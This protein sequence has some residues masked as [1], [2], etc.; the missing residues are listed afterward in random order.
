MDELRRKWIVALAIVLLATGSAFAQTTGRI[1][2]RIVDESGGALPGA[3]ITVTSPSLQGASTAVTDSE[4]NYR[5]PTLPSGT[6]TVKVM[7]SGFKTVEQKAVQVGID[8]TVEVN[9]TMPVA[10]VQETVQVEAASPVV[11]TSSTS[12]GIN[13]KADIFNRL[14]I[15]RNIYSIARIAPGTTEDTVGTAV[16]GST[17]A[18]NQYIIEGLN[19][20]GMERGQRQKQLNF[21][22]VQEIEVKT[23]GLPAEYGR[24][25][26][27][28]LNVVTKSGGNTYEGSFFGFSAGGALQ[29]NDKTEA[30]RPTTT[31]TVTNIDRQ[32]DGG[33]NLG[34]YILR[35]RLWFFGAYNRTFQRNNSVVV[36]PLAVAGSP[37]IGT[38]VPAE[39]NSNLFAGK[40]TYKVSNSQ[41]LVLS[42]NGDPSKREGNVF[43]VAG[44]PSTWLGKQT[45]G[46][47]DGVVTYNAVFGSDFLV[48]GMYGRHNESSKFSGLGKDT[49]QL[50]DQTVSPNL[51]SGGFGGFRNRSSPGTFTSWTSRS[52]WAA[53]S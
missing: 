13:A 6:Y 47:T 2:G 44:P 51:R 41:T 40:V 25:T 26:G 4:G 36:R 10:S 28:I 43:V 45:T 1:L 38:E 11:D 19:A 30:Q 39:I 9:L 34:G 22:F 18:E 21:D 35:D 8:R 14:P 12:I 17:G 48:R 20:T 49:P 31:T 23:G 32:W 42:V 29:A 27:G 46:G 5:F 52:S 15:Q 7:L 37:G 24:M 16:F 33:A 53:T 3:T 50:L